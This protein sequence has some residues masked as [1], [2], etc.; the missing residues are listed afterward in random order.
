MV[1]VA[2]AGSDGGD[3]ADGAVIATIASAVGVNLLLLVGVFAC[4][5]VYMTRRSKKLMDAHKTTINNRVT[6][7]IE[8]TQ[9][10]KYPAAFLTAKRF[11]ELGQ[12]TAF[13]T[14]RDRGLLKFRDTYSEL[15]NTRHYVVF[16][17]HQVC[18]PAHRTRDLGIAQSLLMAVA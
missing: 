16:L 3:G 8:S 12:L 17:S 1:N 2:D 6:T 5:V 4:T 14:L 15:V 7:A 9:K 11:I 13:E 10:L 18:V